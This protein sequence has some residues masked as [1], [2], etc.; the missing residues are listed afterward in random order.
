MAGER[1]NAVK[2]LV[3]PLPIVEVTLGLVRAKA[4]VDSGSEVSV[5]DFS[6]FEEHFSDLGLNDCADVIRV[7]AFKFQF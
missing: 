3:H 6:F 5:I 7:R 4:L 2:S 1:N